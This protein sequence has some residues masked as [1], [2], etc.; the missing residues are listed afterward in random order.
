MTGAVLG[1]I[2]APESRVPSGPTP[3]GEIHISKA[4]YGRRSFKPI[5]VAELDLRTSPSAGIKLAGGFFHSIRA[6]RCLITSR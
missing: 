6:A 5:S 3:L 4:A 2:G 1:S